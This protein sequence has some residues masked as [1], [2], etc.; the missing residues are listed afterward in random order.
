[1]S[2]SKQV[3]LVGV[4]HEIRAPLEL[5]PLPD[6]GF[7]G[8]HRFHADAELRGDFLVAVP[9]GQEPQ[10][11]LFPLTWTGLSPLE[12]EV[13]SVAGLIGKQGV[14]RSFQIARTHLI[15]RI[16]A[17]RWLFESLPVRSEIDKKRK[18]GGAVIATAVSRALVSWCPDWCPNPREPRLNEPTL[19]PK[20]KNFLR[21][22]RLTISIP[23]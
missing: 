20:K 13:P 7:V 22:A 17:C 11:V 12:P 8:F 18:P 5:Q 21:V 3:V 1:M 6:V 14:V 10:K 9:A 16:N 23:L 2:G 4:A 15:G 19:V